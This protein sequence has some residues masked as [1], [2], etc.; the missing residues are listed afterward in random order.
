M[1]ATVT[2]LKKN[3]TNLKM[4]GVAKLHVQNMVIALNAHIQERQKMNR[5]KELEY[6]LLL[7][8]YQYCVEGNKMYHAFMCAGETAFR[9]LGIT[10][11]TPVSEIERRIDELES[12]GY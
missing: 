4:N 5:E 8:V 1:D 9:V 11:D 12:E 7:M 6:A 2:S 3:G 10:L